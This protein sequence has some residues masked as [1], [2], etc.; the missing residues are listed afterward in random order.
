MIGGFFG[1]FIFFAYAVY[2]NPYGIMNLASFF[3]FLLAAVASGALI[4][5]VMR[6]ISYAIARRP[7][8]VLRMAF[9]ALLATV[10]IAIYIYLPEGI[11]EE[12]YK[13]FI[14]DSLFFGLS[15]GGLAGLTAKEKSRTSRKLRS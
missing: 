8:A 13:W 9:G 15:V 14:Q 7:P 1:V 4:G 10:V 11:D 12:Y 3:P 5:A 2:T 6:L